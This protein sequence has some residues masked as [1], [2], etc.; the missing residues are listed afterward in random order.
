MASESSLGRVQ[1]ELKGNDPIVRVLIA[2]EEGDR[3]DVSMMSDVSF[4]QA[5]LRA[6]WRAVGYRDDNWKFGGLIE[7]G[8]GETNLFATTGAPVRRGVRLSVVDPE[9]QSREAE[10]YADCEWPN[11]SVLMAHAFVGIIRGYYGAKGVEAK[12]LRPKK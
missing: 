4:E 11:R 7:T 2:L 3:E 10:F 5:V 1:Q 9:G 6:T 12:P 8:L